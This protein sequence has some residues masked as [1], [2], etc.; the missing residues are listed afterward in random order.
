[1]D[2]LS[3]QI[4]R[5]VIKL[6]INPQRSRAVPGRESGRVL[7]S[8][9]K[10]MAAGGGPQEPGARAPGWMHRETREAV[11]PVSPG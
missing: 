4:D 8:A 11:E 9:G 1:M 7:A 10:G 5:T 6:G 3:G 2:N